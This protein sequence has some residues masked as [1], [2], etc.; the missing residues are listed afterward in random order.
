MLF[1]QHFLLMGSTNVTKRHT[2]KQ[3]SVILTLCLGGCNNVNKNKKLVFQ[4]VRYIKKNE[5][6][7]IL[8]VLV[9]KGFRK[10]D[11]L[12]SFFSFHTRRKSI[13]HKATVLI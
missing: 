3:K 4:F 1:R 13:T 6:A 9:S 2:H 5:N 8:K 10:H 11:F 7:T 12:F